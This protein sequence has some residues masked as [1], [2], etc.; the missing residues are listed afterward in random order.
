M[1]R[2]SH[3]AYHC[4]VHAYKLKTQI[5]LIPDVVNV[6]PKYLYSLDND[7]FAEAFRQLQLLAQ[8]VYDDMFEHP[9]EYGLKL[10]P[11]FQDAS[12]NLVGIMGDVFY[13]IGFAGVLQDERIIVPVDAFKQL[14]KKHRYKLMLDK[15]IAF[16]FVIDNY[17]TKGFEKGSDTFEVSY[18]DYPNV[19][20][21]IKSFI[22][23]AQHY[24]NA[25]TTDKYYIRD[26]V[27]TFSFRP[28]ENPSDWPYEPIFLMNTDYLPD[29][30]KKIAYHLHER[31][32]GLNLKYSG[33]YESISYNKSGKRVFS[34]KHDMVNDT[35]A[36][37]ALLNRPAE[38]LDAIALL[39]ENLKLPFFQS[40]CN[41]CNHKKSAQTKCPHRISY[42]AAGKTFYNCN[43]SAFSFSQIGFEDIEGILKLLSLEYKQK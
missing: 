37:R 33:L 3:F 11:A 20:R 10:T 15:L 1:D 31:L 4:Q 34:M 23:G 40:T 41:F 36:G 19:M 21:T 39:S 6:A 42:E 18:P 38:Y 8:S 28:V 32:K 22:E 16:G 9:D 7:G 26:I 35:I 25:A 30:Q 5:A 14:V 17:N 13:A 27:H 12:V 43:Y 2:N 24:I 29:S